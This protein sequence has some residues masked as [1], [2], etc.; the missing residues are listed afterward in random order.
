VRKNKNSCQV[1]V[2]HTFG[3]SIILENITGQTQA[4]TLI[5][6]IKATYKRT[7]PETACTW[8]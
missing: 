3:G 1:S 7:I 5:G 6:D 2:D 8:L 4:R